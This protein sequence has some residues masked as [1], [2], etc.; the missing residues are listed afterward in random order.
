MPDRSIGYAYGVQELQS[1]PFFTGISLPTSSALFAL[2]LAAA[3]IEPTCGWASVVVA[4][5][6]AG[7]AT[8]RQLTF[9]L[10]PMVAGY[11]AL[12][13]VRAEAMG[14]NAAVTLLV[15]IVV[16]P[17]GIL[18]LR[19]GRGIDL[20]EQERV[21]RETA[22][23]G[24]SEGLR[25]QLDAQ[26]K[27]LL[28]ASEERL[29]TEATLAQAQRLETVGQLTG[30][31]AH[32]FNNLLMAI[33]TNLEL[34]RRTAHEPEKVLRYVERATTSVQRATRV[35]G[36]LLAFSRS[37]RLHVQ[38][39]SVA[40]VLQN[41]GALLKSSLGPNIEI[42]VV[43]DPLPLWLEADPDQ[44]ASALLNLA[45]N[46]RQAML[47]GGTLTIG[48]SRGEESTD[49]VGVPVVRWVN[50]R[51]SDTGIGMPADVL[52]RATEPFFTTRGVG[53][54]SGLGLSQVYGLVKQC[55]GEMSIESNPGCGTSVLM[56]FREAEAPATKGSGNLAQAPHFS[57][58][59]LLVD[60][61]SS[62]R[63]AL[64]D[65]LTDAG[66]QVFEASDSAGALAQVSL[67]TPTVAVLDFLMPGMNGAELAH[68]L[69]KRLPGQP[70]V[71]VS[72]Y[73]ETAALESIAGAVILM[74]PFDNG[75]LVA[76]LKSVFHVPAVP[77]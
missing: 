61:D 21:A 36:Q 41:A 25:V 54:G 11:G 76:A 14:V 53:E 12:Q 52:A 48:V 4:N 8:R 27:D 1:L 16:I 30:G 57:G 65:M 32:D 67:A 13:A 68:E 3:F 37:Q 60:D 55:H 42:A 17:L 59:L 50:I 24:F 44:L 43:G 29:R 34:L 49:A 20:L 35:T 75:H 71:F 10:L 64:A 77:N 33:S 22:Q 70:I 58:N 28:R 15:I 7:S 62:V 19:D 26:A 39:T 47:E 51:V 46:A 31:I 40:A 74:K 73:A 66:F 45:V 18:V 6:I 63:E 72:G 23:E 9:L 2:S 69:R 5:G 38:P 56:R